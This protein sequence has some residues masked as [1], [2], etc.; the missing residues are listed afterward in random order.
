MIINREAFEKDIAAI[1]QIAR[2][3]VWCTRC[4]HS[5]RV[6]G[7][8]AMR[9]DSPEERAA[10]PQPFKPAHMGDREY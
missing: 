1:P 6:D 8:G 10:L 2:G 5:Q 4:G 3:M 9:H 7:V